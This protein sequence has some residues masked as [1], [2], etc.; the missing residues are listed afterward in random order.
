MECLEGIAGMTGT[1]A[2]YGVII[3]P[4][5]PKEAGPRYEWIKKDCDWKEAVE[6]AIQ[7]RK[8][9]PDVAVELWPVDGSHCVHVV[10][11]V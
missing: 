3:N 6:I 9:R 2:D 4:S 11:E 7:N 5:A 8:T 10:R 1:L